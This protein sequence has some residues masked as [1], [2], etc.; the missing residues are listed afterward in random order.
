MDP[1]H[2][3]YLENTLPKESFTEIECSVHYHGTELDEKHD[4]ESLRNL[5]FW[6]WLCYIG[7][8]AVLLYQ[9]FNTFINYQININTEK[10]MSKLE[11]VVVTSEQWNSVCSNVQIRV[12]DTLACWSNRHGSFMHKTLLMFFC[13]MHLV[14]DEMYL[15]CYYA[16]H[17]FMKV[18]N[19]VKKGI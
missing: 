13:I 8:R 3:H 1:K 2:K 18:Q 6:Q 4:E 11:M 17:I 10:Q 9:S 14:N 12:F 16:I 19:V 15:F 7:G 5:V